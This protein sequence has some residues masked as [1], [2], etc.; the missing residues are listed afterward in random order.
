MKLNDTIT[1]YDVVEALQGETGKF[2]VNQPQRR[3]LLRQLPT[4]ALHCQPRVGRQ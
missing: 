1:T 4:G 2:E 3:A